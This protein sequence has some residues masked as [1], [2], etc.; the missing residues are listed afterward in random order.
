MT[1]VFS[2]RMR[3]SLQPREAGA[4]LQDRVENEWFFLTRRRHRIALRVEA[5]FHRRIPRRTGSGRA[6]GL[7]QLRAWGC[8]R[9]ARRQFERSGAP[10]AAKPQRGYASHGERNSD[11]QAKAVQNT[12]PRPFRTITRIHRSAAATLCR[13]P[14]AIAFMGV[15]SAFAASVRPGRARYWARCRD[16][17]KRQRPA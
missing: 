9:G 7:R 10:A 11:I 3:A 12:F 5:V 4:L 2:L 6:V 13:Q 15:S 16:V 1:R 14:I 17:Y 8:R